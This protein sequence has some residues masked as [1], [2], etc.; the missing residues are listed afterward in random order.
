MNQVTRHSNT[1]TTTVGCKRKADSIQTD[2]PSTDAVQK[3]E[4]ED[5]VNKIMLSSRVSKCRCVGWPVRIECDG[6]YPYPR[7]E[8]WCP[9]CQC[10]F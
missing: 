8:N 7:E 1:T 4:E 3:Q 2:N 6:N 10:G 5:E 9:E